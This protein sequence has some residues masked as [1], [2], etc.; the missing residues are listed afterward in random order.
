M[1]RSIA[2]DLHITSGFGDVKV[3]DV[4]GTV[5][6]RVID[7]ANTSIFRADEVIITD[8]M[9]FGEL[10]LGEVRTAEVEIGPYGERSR[11][12]AGV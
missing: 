10:R 2:G 4:R 8:A 1:V 9:G 7:F 5:R 11:G 3:E 6:A 12:R